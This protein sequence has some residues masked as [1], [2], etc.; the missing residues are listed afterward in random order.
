MYMY[1][2]MI[3]TYSGGGPSIIFRPDCCT[4]LTLLLVT[5][6]MS[7]Y[8]YTNVHAHSNIF[9]FFKQ[10]N[11]KYIHNIF[12]IPYTHVLF[13]SYMYCMCTHACIK[14]TCTCRYTCTFYCSGD[15]NVH[16]HT[17]TLIVHCL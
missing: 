4:S 12:M 10:N 3:L 16:V 7:E 13:Y 6:S 1:C 2:I 14:C 11:F 15:S 17:C 9:F 5:Q 8:K